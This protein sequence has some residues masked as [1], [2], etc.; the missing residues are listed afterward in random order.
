MIA[1]LTLKLRHE[2]A[3]KSMGL[4]APKLRI[5]A[6]MAYNRICHDTPR[7]FTLM[8]KSLGLKDLIGAEIGYGLGHN[9][10][11]ILKELPMKF[12]YCIDPYFGEKSYT[13]SGVTV[14][15]YNTQVDNT[16]FKNRKNSLWRTGKVCFIHE[17]SHNAW[18]QLPFDLDF[19]YIDGNH[20]YGYVIDDL[21][22]A[23]L[24]VKEGGYV[25]GHDFFAPTWQVHEAVRDYT[26]EHKIK[27]NLEFPDFWFKK[28]TYK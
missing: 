3:W 14:H 24:H 27:P 22:N 18:K 20:S 23:V 16:E 13:D 25:G 9:A 2:L 8:L 21:R 12:L 4:F 28:E 26:N 17:F 5:D 11:S 19:I 10:E 7:T 6:E 1:E 15:W